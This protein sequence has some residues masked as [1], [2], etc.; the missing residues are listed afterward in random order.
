[1]S[2]KV[3][4]AVSFATATPT[5]DTNAY[6]SGDRM[7]SLMTLTTGN[8][9]GSGLSLMSL[10]VLDTADQKAAFDILFF[11]AAPTIASADNAAIDI[12]DAEMAKAI[13]FVSVTADD[14]ADFGGASVACLKN[15]GLGMLISQSAN[16]IFALCVSRGTPTYAASSLTL[17]FNFALDQ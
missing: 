1:M 4:A 11:N 9:A 17:T 3:S 5:L 7:G 16:N 6:A 15:I 12:S 2:T 14:Y 13:G 8:N 10:T